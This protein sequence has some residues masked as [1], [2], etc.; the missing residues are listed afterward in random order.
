MHK[1]T[2]LSSCFYKEITVPHSPATST[3]LF[4]LSSTQQ[5]GIVPGCSLVPKG[6]REEKRDPGNEVALGAVPFYAG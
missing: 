5:S 1:T 3:I 2:D 4:M 6:G